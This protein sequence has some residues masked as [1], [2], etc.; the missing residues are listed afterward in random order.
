M[1]IRGPNFGQYDAQYIQQVQRQLARSVKPNV[2][3]GLE[4]ELDNE[5]L[6]R[7]LSEDL[8]ELSP[9]ARAFLK[10]LRRRMRRKGDRSLL[11]GATRE[12]FEAL[13]GGLEELRRSAEDEQVDQPP[14]RQHRPPP[15]TRP[16]IPPVIQLSGRSSGGAGRPV[17]STPSGPAAE[18]VDKMTYHAPA[19]A[20]RHQLMRELAVFGPTI[21][22]QVKQFGVRIIVLERERPLTALQIAGM[23]V[24]GP[25]ERTF[26]G[27]PWSLVRG[28]Y[29]SSRR[30]LVVGE[31]NLGMRG[32]SCARHEFAHAYEDTYSTKRRRTLPLSV[33]LWNSFASSRTG[34][35][36][37]YA[38]TNPAEYFAESVEAFFEEGPSQ[39]LKTADPKMYEYLRGLFT[40]A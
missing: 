6:L 3:R 17:S 40:A 24:V 36:S 8:V 27:R 32:R 7:L 34:M 38:S 19:T 29:D 28:L 13:L 12:E 1:E 4:D 22:A 10:K 15:E 31:E 26:D 37:N 30:L 25:G 35:V 21:I 9:E 20:T 33:E 2:L 11:Q 39:Y 16:F 14:D 18:L 23:Y 5:T